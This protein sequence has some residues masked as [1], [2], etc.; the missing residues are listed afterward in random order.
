MIQVATSTTE[1]AELAATVSDIVTRI[2]SVHSTLAHQPLVFLRQDIAFSQ[3]LALLSVADVLMIT[4]LREGMN[5]TCHEFVFC[6]DGKASE[7]KHGPVILSEFT[8]SASVFEGNE[9]SVNPWDYQKCAEAIKTALEMDEVEKDRRYSKLRDIVM[10]NTGEYW[11]N[12]LGKKLAKVYEEH[13][14]RNMMSIPRLSFSQLS[15]KYKSSNKRLFVLDYEGTLANYG[16]VNNIVVTS[17]QRVLDALT[18]LLSDEKN[19]VYIMSSRTP[20]ELELIFSRVPN[21]GLIAENGCFVRE[22]GQEEW[23]SFADLEKTA[24]WKQAVKGILQYYQERVENS[25]VE[26]R[27]CSLMFH[28]ESAPD[29]EAASRQAGDC[30]NHVNDACESQHVRAVPAKNVIIIE[31]QDFDKGTAATHIFDN[32]RHKKVDIQ[33]QTPPDFLL[34]AGNDRDDEVIFRWANE[35]SSNGTISHVTTVSVGVRNTV[36]M[37]TLTQGTTGKCLDLSY[38]GRILPLTCI[39]RSDLGPSATG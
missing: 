27:H 20:E 6:Q 33:G 22:Y 38:Y 17:P 24:A 7:K 2:D 28:Y 5:L 25:W 26:E 31:P 23:V 34:V 29:H 4:S 10:H 15:E 19:I 30:A 16:A 12:N 13:Y 39:L 14:K 21:L 35:L 36:A 9:L 3:Y 11:A 8:G 37:A 1:N 18:E 32:L